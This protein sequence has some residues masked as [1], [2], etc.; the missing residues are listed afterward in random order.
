MTEMERRAIQN[1]HPFKITYQPGSWDKRFAADLN[2]LAAGDD[3]QA[4]Q[5]TRNQQK[6]VWRNV[7]R[8]R[9]QIKEPGILHFANQQLARIEQ[10]E[11]A[12][13]SC[14]Q[15]EPESKEVADGG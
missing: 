11:L 9:K 4:Q 12:E 15:A 13:A 3:W 5:L 6:C 2:V 10:D 7:V 1:L 14:E 8:Y